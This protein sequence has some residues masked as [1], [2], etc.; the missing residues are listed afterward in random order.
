MVAQILLG[1]PLAQHIITDP[2]RIFSFSPFLKKIS[3][4]RADISTPN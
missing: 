4:I 3:I 1:S 2:T